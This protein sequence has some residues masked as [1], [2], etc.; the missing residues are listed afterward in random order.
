MSRSE[1]L[2][3]FHV[4]CFYSGNTAAKPG[5]QFSCFQVTL[6]LLWSGE[7]KKKLVLQQIAQDEY[8]GPFKG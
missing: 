2:A 6:E 7:K 3:G 5:Y 4:T 8:L 1:L